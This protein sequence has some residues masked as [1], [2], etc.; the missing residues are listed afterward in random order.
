MAKEKLYCFWPG[1]VVLKLC[2]KQSNQFK[3]KRKN[4]VIEVLHILNYWVKK[5]PECLGD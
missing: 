5:S 2:E 4:Q 3:G 1:K